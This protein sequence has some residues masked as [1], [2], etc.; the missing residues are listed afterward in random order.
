M[1][2]LP[3]GCR[4]LHWACQLCLQ[5]LTWLCD[6]LFSSIHGLWKYYQ[7]PPLQFLDLFA[8]AHWL[9]FWLQILPVCFLILNLLFWGGRYIPP[10]PPSTHSPLLLTYN[11]WVTHDH[12]YTQPGCHFPRRDQRGH[13]RFSTGAHSS[14]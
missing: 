6:L 10:N 4:N 1:P 12:V 14:G 11:R 9:N 2:A 5:P 8:N 7:G 13:L 3:L